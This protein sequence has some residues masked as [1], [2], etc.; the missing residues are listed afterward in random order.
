MSIKE[1]GPGTWAG[2][3]IKLGNSRKEM[4]VADRITAKVEVLTYSARYTA[5][6]CRNPEYGVHFSCYVAHC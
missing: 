6:F 1:R 3:A 2:V 5:G 4:T